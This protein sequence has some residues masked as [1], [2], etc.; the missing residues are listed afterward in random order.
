MKKNVRKLLSLA[1][2]LVMLLSILPMA[3]F[4]AEEEEEVEPAA[5]CMH[6]YDE[7]VV[8]RYVALDGSHHRQVKYSEYVCLLCGYKYQGAQTIVSQAA[9]TF[10]YKLIGITTNDDT[11]TI[12]TYEKKCTV[13]G[14]TS[15][16][17]LPNPV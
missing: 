8:Y 15:L 16:V 10:T 17:N 5:A 14:Y 4:A 6:S 12:Y 9:H 2:A 3:V 13:C 1:L 11:S 7:T